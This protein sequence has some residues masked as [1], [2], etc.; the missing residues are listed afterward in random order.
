[1]PFIRSVD[2]VDGAWATAVLHRAGALAAD[3]EVR[4]VGVEPVGEGTTFSGVLHRLR[5]DGPSDAPRSLILKL[6]VTG[7]LR[8]MLDAIGMYRREIVFYQEFASQAP[9]CC[10]KAFLAEQDDE[11][12][13]FVLVLEDLA[14]RTSVDQLAG[15]TIEQIQTTVDEL[16]RFH[17]WSW[18]HPRLQIYAATYPAID[19]PLGLAVHDQFSQHFA[20]TW[21]AWSREVPDAIGPATREIGD[22]FGELLGR[23]VQ[24]LATPRTLTHGDLRADNLFLAIDQPPIF[25]D[26]QLVQQECGMREV[27]YLISQSLPVEVRHG[28]D[29]ELARRY[30]DALQVAGVQDYPWDL[31]W[32]QYRVALAYN[33]LYPVLASMGS[34]RATGRKRDLLEEMTRR[35]DAAI[36]DNDPLSALETA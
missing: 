10:P 6:P 9:L 17:S 31:A 21:P 19:S 27:A 24:F 33:L 12:T 36:A 1:V 5:L 3:A 13:D 35:A 7:E 25:V 11:S 4:V 2:E 26:F 23:F 8:G 22:R 18:E 29:E 14:P 15:A 32:R 16:A 34:H 20:A 28:R 30:W